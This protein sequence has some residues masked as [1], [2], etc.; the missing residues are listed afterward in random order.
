MRIKQKIVVGWFILLF[1]FGNTS[2]DS[3]FAAPMLGIDDGW[4]GGAH[5]GYS[6]YLGLIGLE[7]QE[8]HF[9]LTLGFPASLGLR[10][11]FDPSGT[12]WFLGVHVLHYDRDKNEIKDG[13]LYTEKETTLTGM[14]IGYK[15][16]WRK[17]WD[18]TLSLS[19]AFEKEKLKNSAGSRT[20]EEVQS[21][22]GITVGYAF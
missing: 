22:P 19:L 13:I 8:T 18:L 10:Y 7:L 15:W 20:E 2:F 17:H 1:A 16:R 6:P 4:G 5:L 14:G 21:V 9:G 12:Q 3:A 11:Y